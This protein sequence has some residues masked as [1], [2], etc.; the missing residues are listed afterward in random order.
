[1]FWTLRPLCLRSLIE[2]HKRVVGSVDPNSNEDQ[3]QNDPAENTNSYFLSSVPLL[4]KAF[5][6][7]RQPLSPDSPA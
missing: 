1:M 2:L 3:D 6:F 5:A 4:L 7:V